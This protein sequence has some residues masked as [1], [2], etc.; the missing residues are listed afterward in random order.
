MIYIFRYI[1]DMYVGGGGQGFQWGLKLKFR[2][3]VGYSVIKKQKCFERKGEMLGRV[4]E[5]TYI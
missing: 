5:C 2:K 3:E 4:D 1:V